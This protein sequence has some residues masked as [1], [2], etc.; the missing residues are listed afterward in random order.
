MVDL[1]L[2]A[3]E[4]MKVVLIVQLGLINKQE[5]V[6]L[7]V[8]ALEVAKAVPTVELDSVKEPVRVEEVLIVAQVL[9][10]VLEVV[11]PVVIAGLVLEVAVIAQVVENQT[12]MMLTHRFS[13]SYIG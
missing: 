9:I 5:M 12:K 7:A 4:V 10:V 2:E 11:L 3:L 13:E 8:Q 6:T 1:V